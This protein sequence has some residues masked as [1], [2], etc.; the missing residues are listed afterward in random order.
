MTPKNVPGTDFK[1][2]PGSVLTTLSDA[3]SRARRAGSDATGWDAR[4]LLAHAVGHGKP[5]ALDPREDVAPAAATRFDFL[6]ERRI[7][8]VPV[9]HLVGAWDFFGR[10]FSVDSRALVPRPETELL[11]ET[12]LSE[13]PDA[14]RVLDL[15][16]GSGVLAVTW[17]LERPAS[18]AVAVDVSIGAL[19][20]ARANALRHAVLERLELLGGDWTSALSPDVT[21]DLAISNPPYLSVGDAPS[22]SVTVREHDPSAALFAGTDGLDAIRRLLTD[23]PVHLASGAPFLFEIGAG[24]APAVAREVAG[25]GAWRLDRI[26]ADL[27]GIPRVVALRR[28]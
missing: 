25:S 12:A 1:S 20:L 10:P 22:L 3:E 17:L 21:F 5:L 15:G 26:V 8:G 27:A 16:T 19:A 7:A 28:T 18:R 2:A 14:R 9:Q 4:L 24:Q 13:T 11:L 6:W 23:L